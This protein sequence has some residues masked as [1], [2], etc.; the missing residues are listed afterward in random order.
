MEQVCRL[1]AGWLARAWRVGGGGGGRL[2]CDKGRVRWR[3]RAA[4][5]E[6]KPARRPPRWHESSS[7]QPPARSQLVAN[8]PLAATSCLLAR[9]RWPTGRPQ[10]PPTINECKM[11]GN[12]DEQLQSLQAEIKV[13][14]RRRRRRLR[15]LVM[16]IA[17][18]S[19]RLS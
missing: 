18:S 17:R 11:N 4:A 8:S 10:A 14:R 15:R 16:V 13:Q 12:F 9:A 1:L 5:R 6:A 2:V 3:P 7:C 19:R